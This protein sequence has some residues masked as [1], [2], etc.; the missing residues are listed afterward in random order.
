[1]DAR[2]EIIASSIHTPA[3][4]G[5][6]CAEDD[7]EAYLVEAQSSSSES[8]MDSDGMLDWSASEC[9]DYK[10]RIMATVACACPRM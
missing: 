9:K 1:M 5:S 6:V 2:M 7:P 4:A 10:D 3:P 8:E